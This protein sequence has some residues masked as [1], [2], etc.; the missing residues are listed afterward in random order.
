MG[1]ES[2]LGLS[3]AIRTAADAEA[4]DA[5]EVILELGTAPRE[6]D[7]PVALAAALANDPVA[8]SAFDGLAVTH[9][10]EFARWIE[11]AKREETRGR[12]VTQTLQMLH[13][14]KTRR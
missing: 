13:G 4:G 11:E 7:V 6:V 9:R 3:R 14:G 12:R 2:L 10:K 8:R 5:V 1:G